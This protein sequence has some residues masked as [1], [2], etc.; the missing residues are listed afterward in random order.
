MEVLKLLQSKN[1]C[2]SRFL[3]GSRSFLLLAEKGD[4]SG[5]QL[6]QTQREATL[7]ALELYDN[8]VSD[9]IENLPS[10][11]KTPALIEA[12]RKAEE[13][14]TELIQSILLTDKKIISKIEEEKDRLQ[15]QL[16][17]TDKNAQLVKKFK[18]RWISESGEQLDENL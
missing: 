8:K 4:F 2:L 1:R 3:D 17:V 7:K 14:K 12:V 13:Q 6:F 15:K 16:S 11:D 10:A 18:S 9:L 5:L